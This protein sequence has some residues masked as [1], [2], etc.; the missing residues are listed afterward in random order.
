M[1][2][3]QNI[4]LVY[5]EVPKNTYWSFKYALK[6]IRKQSNMPPLGLLTVAALIPDRYRLKLIDMNVTSLTDADIEWADVVFVSG[7]RRWW[8]GVTGWAGEWWPAVPIPPRVIGRSPGSIISS[9]VR[10]STWSGR[11]SNTSS[12]GRPGLS[13]AAGFGR[14]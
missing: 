13:T 12:R 5:P 7:L 11:S 10:P 9:S 1:T 4:L 6:L 14:T 3:L 8:T 2:S